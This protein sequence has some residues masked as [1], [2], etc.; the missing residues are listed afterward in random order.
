[1]A[2]V[3]SY[4]PDM[5][6]WVDETGSDRQHSIRSYGYALRGMR[7]VCHHLNV[8]GRHVSAIPVMTTRGIESVFTTT[9]HVNGDL[10]EHFIC[11]CVLPIILPFDGNNPRSILVMDNASIHHLERIEEI[12]TGVGA[13]ILFL[14][15]TVPTLCH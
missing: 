9:D 10:F 12:I 6:I 7:P 5:L 13:R 14:P 2:E 3:S 8:G 4:H 15:P 1:M 11:E